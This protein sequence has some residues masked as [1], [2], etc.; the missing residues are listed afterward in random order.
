M[1]CIITG[2]QPNQPTKYDK[3]IYH[4]TSRLGVK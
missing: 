3:T 2:K 4:M 1:Q